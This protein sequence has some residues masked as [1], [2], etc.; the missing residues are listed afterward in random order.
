M[1]PA[2][3]KPDPPVA[4]PVEQVVAEQFPQVAQDL[5]VARRVQTVAAVVDPH[6]GEIETAGV[7]PNASTLLDNGDRGLALFRK[8]PSR[9]DARGACTENDYPRFGHFKKR[10]G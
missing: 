8:L 1:Y 6:S 7:A 10:T 3:L 5:G 2:A 9:A 4:G